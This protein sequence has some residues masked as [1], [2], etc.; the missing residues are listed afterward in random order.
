MYV[1][2]FYP[3]SMNI[4]RQY[5]ALA[6]VFYAT[7]FIEERKYAKYCIWNLVAVLFHLSSATGFVILILWLL[8]IDRHETKRKLWVVVLLICSI[9]IIFAA[10]IL[11]Y[12]RYSGYVDS[13]S[14]EFSLLIVG[15]I[16]GLLFFLFL[17]LL[18]GSPVAHCEEPANYTR[19]IT[20][21]YSLGILI[22]TA[23]FVFEFVGR[24]SFYFLIF[25][26]P[27]TA[28]AAFK[29]KNFLLKICYLTLA[30]YFL[31]IK[32]GVLGENG[33]MPYTMFMFN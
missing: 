18:R 3:Q 26:I 2:V 24:L 10:V 14:A 29:E 6:I 33:I 28:V 17:R 1:A 9:P 11:I 15:R 5:L 16:V 19:Y 25:E 13:T 23:G 12:T 8:I 21:L 22:S 27:F 31:V 30:L 4:I 32:I 20:C 7:K